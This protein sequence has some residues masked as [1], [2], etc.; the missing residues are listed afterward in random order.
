MQRPGEAMTTGVTHPYFRQKLIGILSGKRVLLR[1]VPADK[2]HVDAIIEAIE[3][4]L[5]YRGV[6]FQLQE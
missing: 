5:M 3:T 4:M 1:D 6:T 2:K